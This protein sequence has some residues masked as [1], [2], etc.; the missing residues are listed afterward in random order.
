MDRKKDGHIYDWLTKKYQLII[1][2]EADFSEKTTITY[3]YGKALMFFFFVFTIS[4]I[5]G[6]FT[7]SYIDSLFSNREDQKDLGQKVVEY[8]E[9]LKT[10]SEQV[11]VYEKHFKA[12][13]ELM[14]ILSDSTTD[15][16]K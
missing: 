9:R 13:Q 5:A 2:N 15:S 16:I 6:Y 12:Q 14:G 3:N 7:I 11:E 10:L 4:A 1:R 8:S